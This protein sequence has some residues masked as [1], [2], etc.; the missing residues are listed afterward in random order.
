MKVAFGY[1]FHL[2]EFARVVEAMLEK[3]IKLETW[4]KQSNKGIW[5]HNAKPFRLFAFVFIWKRL[6]QMQK[7]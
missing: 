6:M 5:I 3:L 4:E 1:M 2:W 7:E